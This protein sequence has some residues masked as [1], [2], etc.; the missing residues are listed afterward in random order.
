MHGG[1][2]GIRMWAWT[3]IEARPYVAHN[4]QHHDL[5]KP[6]TS[7]SPTDFAVQLKS[8]LLSFPVT[9]FA[10]DGT[11]DLP[12]YRDHIDWLSNFPVAGLFAAGADGILLMPPYLTEASQGRLYAHAARVC[13]ATGLGLVV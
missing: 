13:E 12:G 1:Y 6:V 11:L 2:H 9:H 4:T 10:D 3:G 8:G 5:R 7:Y